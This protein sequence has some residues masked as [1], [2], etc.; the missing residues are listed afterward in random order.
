VQHYGDDSL[1]ISWFFPNSA[2]EFRD[3]TLN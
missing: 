3:S 2:S 1:K